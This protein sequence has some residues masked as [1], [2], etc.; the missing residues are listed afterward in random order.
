MDKFEAVANNAF[1]FLR[2]SIEE[3]DEKRIKYSVIHFYSAVELLLKAR[4]LKEHWALIVNK[5]ELANKEKFLKG[6][7]QSV[8]MDEASKR[9][10]N[11]LEKGLTKAEFDCFEEL[12]KH[13]NQMVHF[14]H[15]AQGRGRVA[16]KQIEHIVME[17]AKGWFYLRGLLVDRWEAEF[18]QFADVVNDI[19]TQMRQHGAYLE[20]KF[21]LLA[22]LIAKKVSKGSHFAEC[23]SC[24]YEAFEWSDPTVIDDGTC[25]VCGLSGTTLSF[26]C[27]DC[28]KP[29]FLF[30]SGYGECVACQDSVYDPEKVAEVLEEQGL[31][32]D[33]NPMDQDEPSKAGCSNCD[34]SEGLRPLES[35]W[36][37]VNCFILVDDDEIG[38]CEWCSEYST[39][40]PENSFWAGCMSCD[41]RAGHH[42]DD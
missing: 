37:C 30:E 42:R 20:A 19:D 13:R 27:L 9:L 29:T 7:F 33:L 25:L 36:F 17:Q 35:G 21:E 28:A 14:T 40:V 5:P 18:I 6:D 12:R 23:P 4:L 31:L 1:D 2:R 3:L 41:G 16:Q 38:Q 10:N 39:D 34:E 22:T 32:R 26:E 15:E 24:H 8:G 11:I